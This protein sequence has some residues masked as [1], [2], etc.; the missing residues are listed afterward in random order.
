MSPEVL[1]R[2]A[3]ANP[4]MDIWALGVILFRMLFGTYPFDGENRRE[5]FEK[6][7]KGEYS[8][9]LTPIVSLSSKSLISKM[10]QVEP[11]NRISTVDLSND[12]WLN[13]NI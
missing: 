5:I 7:K 11:L 10:L 1:I 6:I 12:P 9:P 13:K 2:K 3:P 8:Y 4:S